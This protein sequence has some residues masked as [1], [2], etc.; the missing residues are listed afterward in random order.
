MQTQISLS[1]MEAEYVVLSQASPN[2]SPICEIL[3]EF[4]AVV[5]KIQPKVL[6]I[7]RFPNR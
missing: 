4:M 2:L 6:H 7:M 1:I 3:K 5:F